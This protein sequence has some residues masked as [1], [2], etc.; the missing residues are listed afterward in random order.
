MV[1]KLTREQAQFEV[2]KLIGEHDGAWSWYQLDRALDVR[3]LPTG[4][5]LSALLM[6]LEAG[7]WV[8]ATP[9]EDKPARLAVTDKGRERLSAAH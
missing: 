8:K 6:D 3:R 4:Y 1:D 2:L 5:S 7:G 9:V